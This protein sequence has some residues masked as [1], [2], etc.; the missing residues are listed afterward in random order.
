MAL[1]I[2][3]V[4]E[5]GQI[6]LL[7]SV[8][9][10]EGQQLMIS[11]EKQSERDVVR[12]ALGDLIRPSNPDDNRDAWVEDLADEVAQELTKGHSLSEILIEERNSGW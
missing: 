8:E 6:K 1:K 3:A 11:L 4:Y 7:D 5:D 10:Q 2:R 9:L 12:A